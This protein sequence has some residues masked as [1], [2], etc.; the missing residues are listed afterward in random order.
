ML[1]FDG[2]EESLEVS[3]AKA[4]MVASLDHFKEESGAVLKRLCEKLE[5]VTLLIVVDENLLSLQDVNIFLHLDI[6]FADTSAEVVV[7]GVG[8]FVEEGDTTCLHALNSSNNVLGSHGNVLNAS[9]AVVFAEL[10]DLRFPHAI[11][12]LVDGHLDLLVE[13][14]HDDRA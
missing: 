10:L 4:L 7:V 5:K 2:F 14:S 6:H 8:D 12:G 1:S 11:C 13:V 9:A 3:S